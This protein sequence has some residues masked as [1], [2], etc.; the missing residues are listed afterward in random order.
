MNH[1]KDRFEYFYVNIQ[2]N[3][4]IVCRILDNFINLLTF[5]GQ[6]QMSSVAINV[7]LLRGFILIC[8]NVI[9]I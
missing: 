2:E 9:T 5:L 6:L 8:M 3:G 4:S 1:N 7:W